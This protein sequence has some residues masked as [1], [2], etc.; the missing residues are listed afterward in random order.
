MKSIRRIV[1]FVLLF[2][3]VYNTGKGQQIPLSN[4]Y[5]HNMFSANPAYAATYDDVYTYMNGKSYMWGMEGAPETLGLGIAYPFTTGDKKQAYDHA[6]SFR[7]D[8]D[9]RGVFNT[10]YADLGYAHH[11]KLTQ[12]QH[13][14]L[15]AGLGITNKNI[16][17]GRIDMFSNVAPGFFNMGD[18]A[19]ASGYYSKTA[20]L[21]SAG[22]TY[23][24][25]GLEANVM[26]PSMFHYSGFQQKFTGGLSY[27][28]KI[29]AGAENTFFQ[30]IPS[31]YYH[32]DPRLQ[33]VY[34][35]GLKGVYRNSIWL[36]TQ[37][38]SNKSLMFS[39]GISLDEYL[40]TTPIINGY[41]LAYG[42]Q[43]GLGHLAELSKGTH[44]VMLSVN[45]NMNKHLLPKILFSRNRKTTSDTITEEQIAQ[46][47]AENEQLQQENARMKALLSEN[48]LE[49]DI[50]D[51]YTAKDDQVYNYYYVILASFYNERDAKDYKSI[52]DKHT[53]V[54]TQIIARKDRKYFFIYTNRY[55]TRQKAVD[56]INELNKTNVVN[57]VEGNIWIYGEK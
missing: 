34:D 12:K 36:Q 41:G 21:A 56:K 1:L 37:Y 31:A 49:Q 4:F 19:L 48:Q 38:R 17:R 50:Q 35:F 54:E 42:Y 10:I 7:L 24:F 57:Y 46:L 9:K 2:S 44:E 55:E 16:V 40:P 18:P 11:L 25:A 5:L 39:A 32:Y 8:M 26:L 22:L 14:Y 6:L 27:S 28:F 23:R 51:E 15:G 30:V 3:G 53:D 20:L 43:L 52:L 33:D 29:N 45:L 13:L 47:K